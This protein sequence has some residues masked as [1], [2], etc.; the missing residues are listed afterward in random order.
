MSHSDIEIKGNI[1][2]DDLIS[3][4]E[5]ANKEINLL[6]LFIHAYILFFSPNYNI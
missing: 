3:I 6:K 2:E 1:I 5:T 4:L